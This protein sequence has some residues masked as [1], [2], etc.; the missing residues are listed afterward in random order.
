MNVVKTDDIEKGIHHRWRKQETVNDK[1]VST[2]FLPVDHNTRPSGKP[3]VFETMVF[4][5]ENI[6]IEIYCERYSTYQE[7]LEGHERAIE[8]VKNGCKEND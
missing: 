4:E 3:L 5:D 1:F 6:G 8:W 7:A 2:V